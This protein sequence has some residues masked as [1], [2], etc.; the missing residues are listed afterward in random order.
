M[1]SE[2]FHPLDLGWLKDPPG[3]LGFLWERD[4]VLVRR[5]WWP[6]DRLK[7]ADNLREHGAKN[8]DPF[9]K[10]LRESLVAAFGDEIYRSPPGAKA[11]K[12]RGVKVRFEPG[13]WTQ[14]GNALFV[15]V[16]LGDCTVENVPLQWIP[17]SHKWGLWKGREERNALANLDLYCE[18]AVAKT[19]EESGRNP[20]VTYLGTR[21]DMVILHPGVIWRNGQS[22]DGVL[23]DRPMLWVRFTGKGLKR[24]DGT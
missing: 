14:V 1:S 15:G 3:E 23:R 24:G 22:V 17:G 16:A 7:Q 19:S 10:V 9:L 4:G 20:V 11:D 8:D 18:R 5:N 21:G 12:W 2:L 13:E 6:K